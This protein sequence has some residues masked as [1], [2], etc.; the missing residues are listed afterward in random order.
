MKLSPTVQ[1]QPDTSEMNA[2]CAGVDIITFTSPSAVH[3][4]VNIVRNNSLDPLNLPGTPLFACIGP[5]TKKAAEGMS[6]CDL[7]VAN[8]HTTVGL[9]EAI[10][11]LV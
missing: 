10:S 8:E 11:K 1:R 5:L 3:N 7:V 9:I 4:F 6:F 2:L